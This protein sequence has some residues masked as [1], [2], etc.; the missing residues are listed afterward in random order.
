MCV[1]RAAQERASHVVRSSYLRKR[2]QSKMFGLICDVYFQKYQEGEGSRL[3]QG[4]NIKNRGGAFVPFKKPI[5]VEED[6]KRVDDDGLSLSIPTNVP[7]EEGVKERG[8]STQLN[9]QQQ[10]QKKHRRC[11]SPELHKQFVDALQ[12]LGGPKCM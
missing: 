12:Q 11:W 8:D 9:T 7:A 4:C 3:L 1:T 6:R 2:A 5:A 10:Q